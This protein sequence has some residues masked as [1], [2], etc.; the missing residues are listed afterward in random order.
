MMMGV[1]VADAQRSKAMTSHDDDTVTAAVVADADA[2]PAAPKPATA[3]QGLAQ[4]VRSR[5]VSLNAVT[6]G[7]ASRYCSNSTLI[8]PATVA[9]DGPAMH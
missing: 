1:V 3:S 2:A 7:G 9:D 6:K 5:N 4:S 8:R